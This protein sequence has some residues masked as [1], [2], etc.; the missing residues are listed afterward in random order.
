MKIVLLVLILPFVSVVHAFSA[1][2]RPTTVRPDSSVLVEEA[3]KV[4]AAYGIESK[5]A[6]LAWETVEEM[7]ASDN[8]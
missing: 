1:G 6:A 7:D 5:E 4:T 8:R 2:P 3:L